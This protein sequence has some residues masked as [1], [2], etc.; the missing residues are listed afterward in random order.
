MPTLFLIALS[1]KGPPTETDAGPVPIDV[2][3][4]ALGDRRLV[5]LPIAQLELGIVDP[6]ED[7]WSYIPLHADGMDVV[8][9]APTGAT[10]E[11]DIISLTYPDDLFATVLLEE[12]GPDGWKLHWTPSPGRDVGFFR[13]VARGDA[14]EAYYG[15]GE[16]FDTPHHRGKVREMQLET[17]GDTESGYNERHVPIPL[18]LGTTGWALFVPDDHAM[19]FELGTEAPDEVR[20]TVGTGVSSDAGLPVHVW[21]EERPVDLTLHY[22]ELTGF[23]ML[24]APWALGPIFWRDE[25]TG[26]DEVQSDIDAMRDLDLAASALWID[27]PYASAVNS[28][29]FAPADYADPQGMIDYAHDRGFR[30][31][32][33]HTPY[34]DVATG[35]I[36]DEAIANGYFP[37]L[38][39]AIVLQVVNWGALV[40]FTNPAATAWWQTYIRLYTDMG[41]EGFKLDFAEDVVPGVFQFRLPWEFADGSD[42]RTMHRHYQRLYHQAYR[43]VLGPENGF[44]LC[45]TGAWG[46]QAT[47]TIIWP[48]DIDGTLSTYGQDMGDYRSVGGLPAAVVASIG[49][50]PSGFPF[51]GSDTGGYRHTPPDKETFTRWFEHTALSSVMQIGMSSSDVAWEYVRDW[52]DAMLD[53][54]RD[55]TR[56]HLRL[57]PYLWTH[58]HRIASTGHPIQV[59]LGLAHPELGEHFDYDYLLGDA[60]LVAPVVLPGQTTRRVVL[61][62]GQWVDWFDGDVR[63]AG[64][65]V[66]DAPLSK[67]PVFLKQGGMVPLLRPTIDTLAPVADTTIDSFATDPGVLTV[68]V[69]PGEATQLEL[70]DG[71]VLTQESTATGATL[72]YTAGSVYTSG[73]VFEVLGS[74]PVVEATLSSDGTV[75]VAL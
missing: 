1:C 57:F 56:L 46:D 48:G 3:D 43:D 34:A 26:Q 42:E 66:V 49:L 40:D 10:R 14:T 25:T 54:Y 69:F 62:E 75:E 17:T 12:D 33:W 44:L 23:P 41:I 32:L 11:G 73:V 53:D 70:Y 37:P 19:Q 21:L 7:G 61:P 64:E 5:S 13:M 2:I 55:Y 6:G 68:R 47:G 39:P 35:S 50:G 30:M 58:A 60:L 52:D 36:H 74:G 71:T 8:W 15:L 28:F 31:G 67:I 22:Y 29:D 72:G 20:I 9:R 45:R 27:R 63:S 4:F 65:H 38:V 59:P 16:T 18:V 51:F 24:P